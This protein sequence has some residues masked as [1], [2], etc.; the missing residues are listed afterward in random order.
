M[1]KELMHVFAFSLLGQ[2]KHDKPKTI[3]KAVNDTKLR[4]TKDAKKSGMKDTS[5]CHERRKR[6]LQIV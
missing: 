4:G 3:D 2:V 1:I 6:E 5:C